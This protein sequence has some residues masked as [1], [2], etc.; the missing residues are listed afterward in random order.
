MNVVEV[1]GVEP[2]PPYGLQLYDI[3]RYN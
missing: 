2:A 1:A 3:I